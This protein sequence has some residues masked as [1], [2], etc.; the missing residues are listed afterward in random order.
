MEY[1]SPSFDAHSKP[2]SAVDSERF[3]R[4]ASTM[5]RTECEAGILTGGLGDLVE[6]MASPRSHTASAARRAG[7]FNRGESDA[8]QRPREGDMD[9]SE[10]S[11][12]GGHFTLDPDRDVD[13]DAGFPM[14]MEETGGG[15]RQLH[16][17]DRNRDRD[18]DRERDRTPGTSTSTNTVRATPPV[19]TPNGHGHSQNQNHPSQSHILHTLSH[20][21]S[22]GM[23]RRRASSPPR[24]ALLLLLQHP[25]P[26]P[27]QIGSGT[28]SELYQRRTSG[29]GHHHLQLSAINRAS[30]VLRHHPHHASVSSAS[31]AGLP[32]SSYASSAGLS[33]GGSSSITSLSSQDRLSP[34]G[35]S[36][37][38][39]HY[40]DDRDSPYV[41]SRSL[42]P[43]LRNGSSLP[44]HHRSIP[45]NFSAAAIARKM[46]NDNAGRS[47]QQNAP[48]LRADVHICSC[49]PKKPKK[50]D[51]LE[52][53]R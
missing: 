52:D 17:D 4:R 34:R 53:L 40:H 18:R 23:K 44:Q 5:R 37:S 12:G 16:L 50:F 47:K 3:G 30:P 39:E 43:N 31:S 41:H 11:Y 27:L 36:P 22:Q 26:A 49:C 20:S 35:I 45:E 48:K 33:V 32:N 13:F 9:S 51:T 15:L 38:S 2:F 21:R 1:R 10:S 25:A 42:D 28:G 6:E 7:R 19:T 29:P 8:E 14:S 46:S 24:E